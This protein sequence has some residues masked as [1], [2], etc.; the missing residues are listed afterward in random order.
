MD[1]A[2]PARASSPEAAR[3]VRSPCAVQPGGA[4]RRNPAEPYHYSVIRAV[5]RNI[6]RMRW[7]GDAD[8][9]AVDGQRFCGTCAM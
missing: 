7:T 9:R 1:Q 5:S 6:A 4:M 8:P 3:S 2:F